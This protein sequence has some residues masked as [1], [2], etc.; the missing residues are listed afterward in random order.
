MVSFNPAG[1]FD[2]PS[3][4]PFALSEITI[5]RSLPG[6]AA[7]FA[8]MGICLVVVELAGSLAE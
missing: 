1:G 7:W 5:K 2:Q 6:K 3:A 4:D 8:F